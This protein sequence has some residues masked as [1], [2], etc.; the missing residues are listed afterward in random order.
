VIQIVVENERHRDRQVTLDLSN[1]TTRGGRPAPIETVL[2]EP[3]E[4]TLPAC[5]EQRI[6][7]VV[8]IAGTN[9]TS[10]DQANTGEAAVTPGQR[11]L[12]DVDDCL[13]AVADLR[14]AGCDHRPL[15]VALA[16]QPRECGAYWVSCAC[17]CC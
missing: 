9:Q 15:R 4:F 10:G 11:V 8:R 1:W 14:L 3:K 12:T 2:L 16:I 7:L 17:A 6:T 13:V 5:G